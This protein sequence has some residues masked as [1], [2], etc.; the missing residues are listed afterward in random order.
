MIKLK[1]KYFSFQKIELYNDLLS[2]TFEYL[3][4]NLPYLINDRN[5]EKPYFYIEVH[6]QEKRFLKV[7][8][9]FNQNDPYL[10]N[11]YYISKYRYENDKD[12][13]EYKTMMKSK[14]FYLKYLDF[15]NIKRKMY[16]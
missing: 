6:P 13:I 16:S 11:A 4:E 7:I 1:P 9:G 8:I 3:D 15:T 2:Y 5:E 10:E 14:N 12:Y